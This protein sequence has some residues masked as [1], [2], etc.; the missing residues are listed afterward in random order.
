MELTSFDASK[1]AL[2]ALIVVVLTATLFAAL[3]KRIKVESYSKASN[4]GAFLVV[5]TLA[6]LFQYHLI[7]EISTH[8]NGASVYRLDCLHSNKGGKRPF[9]ATSDE[10][11]NPCYIAANNNSSTSNSTDL[12]DESGISSKSLGPICPSSKISIDS[13][14]PFI[15]EARDCQGGQKSSCSL[16]DPCTPCEISRFN[17]FSDKKNLQIYPHAR[18]WTRCQTCALSNKYGACNFKDGIGPYCWKNAV[19]FEVVPCER[20]CTEGICH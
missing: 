18:G 5:I 17:E 9:G 11:R 15:S 12:T 19:S 10:Y 16:S 6:I 8:F 20:C 3:E 1:F 2:T 14:D 4:A 7:V 13:S